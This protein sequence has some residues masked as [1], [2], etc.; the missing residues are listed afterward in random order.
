[1]PK[2]GSGTLE[3]PANV[4]EMWEAAGTQRDALFS[5]WAKCGGVKAVFIE[6]VVV[7]SKKTRSKKLVVK[8]GFYSKEDMKTEPRIEKIVKWAESK[9]LVR[10]CE[11]DSDTMEYWVNT[12]TEGTLTKEDIDEITTQKEY[13]GDGGT[14]LEM[15]PLV[16]MG[17]APDLDPA[18]PMLGMAQDLEGVANQV[19]DY[20]RETLRAKNSL[21]NFIDRLR[22]AAGSKNEKRASSKKDQPGCCWLCRAGFETATEHIAFEHLGLWEPDWI[23]TQG[24]ANTLPWLSPG[25]PIL[26][27]MLL[28]ED[29][30]P[31]F[32]RPDLF[33]VYHS[34]VG[35]DFL[36]SSFIYAIQIL[37]N[38]GGVDRNIQALNDL[39]KAFLRRRKLYLHCRTLSPDTLG[40]SSTKEYPEG[41]WSKNQDTA[42]LMRF[43]VELLEDHPRSVSSDAMLTEMLLAARA[44]GNFMRT[45]FQADYFMSSADCQKLLRS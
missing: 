34:G 36:G 39:L 17:S 13:E 26:Q 27:Y 21:Q 11:Y 30:A 33:H 23:R 20:L 28:E 43:L 40:Y 35:K 7:M 41:H 4:M 45:S 25:G 5:M 22:T 31:S 10:P 16:Q 38:R 32:F 2:E 1:M 24:L 18:D 42:V 29:D 6:R 8:G 14:D 12:R 44:M 19:N 3:V 9:R 37:L 15:K